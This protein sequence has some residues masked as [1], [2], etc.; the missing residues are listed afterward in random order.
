MRGEKRERKEWA[1]GDILRLF[2]TY[3]ILLERS[4]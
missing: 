3:P 4:R 2:L 1:A